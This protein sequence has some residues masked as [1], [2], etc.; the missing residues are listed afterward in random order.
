MILAKEGSVTVPFH[1]DLADKSN[2]YFRARGRD[3][4]IEKTQVL[5]GFDTSLQLVQT[6]SLHLS[7]ALFPTGIPVLLI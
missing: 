1:S 6:G 4:H 3:S 2:H 7:E 5:I